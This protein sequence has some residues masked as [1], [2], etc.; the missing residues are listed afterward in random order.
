MRRIFS[1]G[2]VGGVLAVAV[3]TGGRDGAFRVEALAQRTQTDVT[4]T[5]SNPA[6]HPKIGIPD[7]LINGGDAELAAAAKTVAD[8]LWN[9]IDFEREYYVIPRAE[10]ASIPVR[11]A[12]SLPYQQW[13]DIGAH[14]VLVGSASRSGSSRTRRTEAGSGI[15]AAT[16][17]RSRSTP[18]QQQWRE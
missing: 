18:R 10:T 17:G 9:D 5:L 15:G 7:F 8:V 3:T 2:I 14:F 12:D 11:P 16:G 4:I 13:T 6:Y 1:V